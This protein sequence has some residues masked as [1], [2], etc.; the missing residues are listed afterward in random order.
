MSERKE[1]NSLFSSIHVNRTIIIMATICL[2]IGSVVMIA[3]KIRKSAK[4]AV[5]DVIDTITVKQHHKKA[6]VA[7]TS[8][9]SLNAI[10]CLE[11]YN[12]YFIKDTVPKKVPEF[13]AEAFMGYEYGDY[14]YFKKIDLINLTQLSANDSLN[15]RLIGEMGHYYKGVSFL[16]LNDTEQAILNLTWVINNSNYLEYL[17]KARWYLAMAYL[18]N[19]NIEKAIDSLIRIE[20]NNSFLLYKTKAIKLLDGL[21]KI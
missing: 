15:K 2:L 7:A 18:K 20:K 10:K 9:D 14:I 17:S 13:L 21:R 3:Y 8:I 4:H 12:Q 5:V 19:N 11:L 1:N 16:L 6:P